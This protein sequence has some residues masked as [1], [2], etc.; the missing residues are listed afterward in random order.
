MQELLQENLTLLLAVNTAAIDGL[1]QSRKNKNDPS[2]S[3][4]LTILPG[5][6][7]FDFFLTLYIFF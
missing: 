1:T 5:K 2:K 6:T 3:L 4:S 7:F